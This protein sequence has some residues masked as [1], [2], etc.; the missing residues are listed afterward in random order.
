M[1]TTVL[2][3]AESESDI[4]IIKDTP[5]RALT[6][7][8]WDVYC[9]NL[10]ENWPRIMVPHCISTNRY[11][12]LGREV[13]QFP[14]TATLSLI[15]KG[16]HAGSLIYTQAIEVSYEL[17]ALTYVYLGSPRECR[18]AVPQEKCSSFIKFA[19]DIIFASASSSGSNGNQTV[20]KMTFMT[21]LYKWFTHEYNNY[22][23]EAISISHKT[24]RGPLN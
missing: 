6:G 11:K 1:Y 20:N 23:S 4:R 15:H 14:L 7:E 8:L 10:G 24:C 13:S 16:H 22:K 2:T 18:W 5:Y 9:E 21:C 17:C 3:V 12:G 19:L